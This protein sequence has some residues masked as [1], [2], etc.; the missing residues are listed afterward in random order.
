MNRVIGTGRL[1]FHVGAFEF[2]ERYELSV[3]L[4]DGS[5]G[6]RVLA[7]QF[8]EMSKESARRA[9]IKPHQLLAMTRAEAQELSD[10]L[11]EAGIRPQPSGNK[12]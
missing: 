2:A 4:A 7:P 6:T 10:V 1:V 12:L 11:A 3:F 8:E 9:P 5:G